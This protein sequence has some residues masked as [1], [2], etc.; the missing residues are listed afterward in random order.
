MD[1]RV[2]RL[3]VRNFWESNLTFEGIKDLR[4]YAEIKSA[5]ALEK[6]PV[7]DY[8]YGCL[9]LK[10]SKNFSEQ[11]VNKIYCLLVEDNMSE[12]KSMMK[13]K[14][15][16]LSSNTLKD[17]GIHKIEMST[18]VVDNERRQ[19]LRI[20]QEAM[21]CDDRMLLEIKGK[22]YQLWNLVEALAGS[23][24]A[25][26]KS[27][28][29]AY[30]T[31]QGFKNIEVPISSVAH[32]PPAFYYDGALYSSGGAD[33]EKLLSE[34]IW[35]FLEPSRILSPFMCNILS[36]ANY[37][38]GSPQVI[39]ALLDD[40]SKV[41]YFHIYTA[42][43]YCNSTWK[44][45]MNMSGYSFADFSLIDSADPLVMP[46]FDWGVTVVPRQDYGVIVLTKKVFKD[47]WEK[48]I[49]DYIKFE[50]AE[51]SIKGKRVILPSVACVEGKPLGDFLF[52]EVNFRGDPNRIVPD[53]IDEGTKYGLLNVS[54]AEM[55]SNLAMGDKP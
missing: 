24:S 8:L 3:C 48:E 51:V 28:Y 27:M 39:S 16:E 32:K 54:A 31:E 49:F 35:D 18:Y 10:P 52:G 34:A 41:S 6:I 53:N 38:F 50:K 37:R 19:L 1:S 13:K 11:D 9:G 45:L 29:D 15:L 55:A 20:I 5:A 43:L 46:F 25:E 2:L 36:E 12:L 26:R 21:K 40:F 4:F 14:D 30:F 7:K 47:L 33:I 23:S 42:C 44:H 22:K 17:G